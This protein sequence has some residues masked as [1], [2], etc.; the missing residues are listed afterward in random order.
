MAWHRG[1]CDLTPMASF[2]ENSLCSDITY[3]WNNTLTGEQA[4]EVTTWHRTH[5][6]TWLI[7][8][9]SRP[10]PRGQTSSGPAG[11]PWNINQS[12]YTWQMKGNDRKWMVFKAMILYCKNILVQ[13]QPELM[14][15]T[16]ICNELYF[17]PRLCTVRLLLVWWQPW[18]WDKL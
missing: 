10:P 12:M 6:S 14:R 9:G 7:L 1:R 17:R 11:V 5:R 3:V 18:L 13:G 15:W 8:L 16:L 4:S 2:F